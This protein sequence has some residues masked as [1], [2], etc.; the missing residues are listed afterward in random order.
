MI[1]AAVIYFHRRQPL[2]LMLGLYSLIIVVSTWGYHIALMAIRIHGSIALKNRYEYEG[3]WLTLF[4]GVVW[5][6][7]WCTTKEAVVWYGRVVKDAATIPGRCTTSVIQWKQAAG[8]WTMPKTRLLPTSAAA[9]EK[10]GKNKFGLHSAGTILRPSRRTLTSQ[11]DAMSFKDVSGLLNDAEAP[12]LPASPKSGAGDRNRNKK[13]IHPSL[14]FP[15]PP[16]GKRQSN[17]FNVPIPLPNQKPPKVSEAYPL[18][19]FAS[20]QTQHLRNAAPSS[21]PDVPRS[22]TPSPPPKAKSRPRSKPLPS[23]PSVVAYP[24]DNGKGSFLELA[25]TPREEERPLIQRM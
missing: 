25:A 9:Q 20:N 6:I 7:L 21:L 14:I 10:E 12:P 24:F 2:R 3:R 8:K 17:I 15:P 22:P 11:Y 1:Y 13:D 18:Q 5:A 19:P 16:P 4:L 23:A